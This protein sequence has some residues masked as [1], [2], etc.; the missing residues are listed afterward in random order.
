MSGV[1]GVKSGTCALRAADSAHA[2]AIVA[3]IFIKCLQPFAITTST[4]ARRAAA[5]DSWRS[6]KQTA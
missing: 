3:S 1:C 6:G 4:H 5:G 2:A